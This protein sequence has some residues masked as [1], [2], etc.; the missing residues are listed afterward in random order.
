MVQDTG[1]TVL[2]PEY[3]ALTPV[4]LF[5]NKNSN[6][7]R[8]TIEGAVTKPVVRALTGGPLRH[9]ALTKQA[10]E[11]PSGRISNSNGKHYDTTELLDSFIGLSAECL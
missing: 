6:N 2:T 3:G 4:R 5:K 9:K 11:G 8:N 10:D 1:Q 7:I